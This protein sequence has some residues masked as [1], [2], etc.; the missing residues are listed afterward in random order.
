MFRDSDATRARLLNAAAAEFAAHGI[1]GARVDRIAIAARA[2]KAQIYHY[3][4][5]KEALFEAVFNALVAEAV[6]EIPIDV[7]DLPGYAATLADGY[8]RHPEVARLATWY[9]L[10][11]ADS[12]PLPAVVDSFH[13]KIDAIRRAQADGILP[14][15]YTPDAL[16][17]LILHIAALWTT[18][19]PE[20]NAA[21]APCPPD[22]RRDIVADAVR[23]LLD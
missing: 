8:D 12:G 5:S 6:R 2:N 18:T 14:T 10:E 16:L 19:S 15:H 23:R 3:Y 17:A 13:D 1:A 20:F 7:Q 11:R 4:G 21:T 22:Q 9:R